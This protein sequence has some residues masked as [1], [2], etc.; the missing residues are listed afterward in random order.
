MENAWNE[1]L[2][3][4]KDV[5]QLKQAL[6]EQMNR[7]FF[8]QVSLFSGTILLVLRSLKQLS[9][10]RK[11]PDTFFVQDSYTYLCVSQAFG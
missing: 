1:Y 4:E 6:Q 8:T 9:Y 3:L 2:K 10:R 11:S 5:N 7:S